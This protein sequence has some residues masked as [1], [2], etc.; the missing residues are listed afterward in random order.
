MRCEDYPCCG[1]TDGLPCD[2]TAPDYSNDP[3]LICD[4]E[5]GV[6]DVWED[7]DHTLDHDDTLNGQPWCYGCDDYCGPSCPEYDPTPCC[8]DPDC[9]GRGNPANC[10]FP[11]Y[12]DNH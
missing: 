2:W 1:H 6:C 5:A 7:D 11:G 9:P 4:H 3:H 8:P 10:T 12:A